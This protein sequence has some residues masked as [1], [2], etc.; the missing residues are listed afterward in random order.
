MSQ[1]EYKQFKKW[2]KPT[3]SKRKLWPFSLLILLT[4]LSEIVEE[5]MWEM[6][7]QAL[8]ALF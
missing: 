6:V 5:F 1:D 4:Y 7:T 8:K 2:G 3:F